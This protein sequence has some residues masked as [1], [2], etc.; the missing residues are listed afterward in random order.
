MKRT[1]LLLLLTVTLARADRVSSIQGCTQNLKA[2]ATGL[3]YYASDHGGGYPAGLQDLVPK[4]LK[5]IPSCP[6]AHKDTYSAS[7][8]LAG[9]EGFYMCCKGNYHADFGLKP[10]EP[11]CS[12]RHY[13]GPTS[14]MTRLHKLEDK[15][16]GAKPVVRCMMNLKN[17]ATSLEMYASDHNGRYPQTL[18]GLQ[19][20]GYRRDLPLCLDKDAYH[21]QVKTD[22]DSFLLHCPGSNHAKDGC[23]KNFPS[24]DPERGLKRE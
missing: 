2:I 5:S 24:Y 22:P 6:A 19:P 16:T 13:L 3:E 4:Y 12:A 18:Q 11:T 10:D 15:R 8:R 1:L 21:Y 7:W 20:D 14:L 9:G 17:L 23:P